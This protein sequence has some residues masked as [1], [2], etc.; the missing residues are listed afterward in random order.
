MRQKIGIAFALAKKAEVLFLDEPTSGLDPKNIAEFSTLIQTLKSDG[1]AILMT[2]HDL[3][4][5]IHD[6]DKIGIMKAGK[7]LEI[8]DAL[9]TTHCLLEKKYM[10]HM[11]A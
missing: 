4:R 10:S 9:S 1:M 11:N 5:T 7:L 2:S 8:I 6:A 3:F